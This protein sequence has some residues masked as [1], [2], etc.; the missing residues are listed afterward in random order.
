MK[1]KK[2]L[3]IASPRSGSTNYQ[4]YLQIEYDLHG[5]GEID[6]GI[7][8]SPLNVTN[9][10]VVPVNVPYSE[11][12]IAEQ[13]REIWNNGRGAALKMFPANIEEPNDNLVGPMVDF[14]EIKKHY[15]EYIRTA[16]VIHFLQRDDL[17]A[18]ILSNYFLRTNNIGGYE[19]TDYNI[20]VAVVRETLIQR[21]M[22]K[23]YREFIKDINNTAEIIDVKTTD[24]SK[25]IKTPELRKLGLG[26]N[27]AQ[28]PYVNKIMERDVYKRPLYK[29][30]HEV[31]EQQTI[32]LCNRYNN[33]P[34]SAYIEK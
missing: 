4:L 29:M 5:M 10:V 22:V 17:D 20:L 23:Y 8:R 25:L 13:K 21:A 33:K 16:D 19:I 26:P 32:E 14:K 2:H 34:W 3:I 7:I 28:H 15:Y 31:T 1:N 18:Q 11:N 30:L 24:L 9:N 12:K 6:F 27:K